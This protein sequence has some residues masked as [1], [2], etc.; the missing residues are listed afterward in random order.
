M[1]FSE[2]LDVLL[3]TREVLDGLPRISIVAIPLPTYEPNGFAF[4]CRL[5]LDL[6]NEVLYLIAAMPVERVLLSPFSRPFPL[7]Q[8]RDT[9]GVAATRTGLSPLRAFST[10]DDDAGFVGGE[11]GGPG[12]LYVLFQ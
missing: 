3:K 2:C 6:T 4:P 10:H 11:R 1:R 8:K 9:V 12:I 7:R 5:R